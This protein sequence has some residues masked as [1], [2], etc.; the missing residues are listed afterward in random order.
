M[1][2]R[3]TRTALALA[4]ALASGGV[5]ALGLG[6][7][8][9]KS[10]S[11]QPLLAE[12]PIVSS[13]PAE[14]EQLQARLASP[15]TFTRIGL[16]PPQGIVSDLQFQVALDARGNP[17]IRVTSQQPV[18]QPL[19]TFLV[20]VDWGQGRL[21]REY[22]A[23]IDTPKTVS[24]PL[25]PPI[26]APVTAPSN[27]IER[28]LDPAAVIASDSP[29]DPAAVTP[30]A[31]DPIPVVPAPAPG[32]AYPAQPTAIAIAPP[33]PSP[34]APLDAAPAREDGSIAVKR[35]D[36]LSRIASGLELGDGYSLDQTMV[37][38][39]RANPDAFI[40]G[41]VNRLKQGAV[42]RVPPGNEV[43]SIDAGEASALVRSQ[44]Q[45]WRQARRPAPQPA[46]EAVP[47]AVAPRAAGNSAGTATDAAAAAGARLE[48][49]PPGASRAARAGTQSG[50]NA[51][52]GGEMLRQ[53]L[54]ESKESLAARE[55]ELQDLKG[56]V[57]EL[58]QLQKQ[59]QQLIQLKDTELAAAQQ[60]LSESNQKQAAAQGGAML[61][62]AITG[63]VLLLAVL[64][65]WFMRRRP[66]KPVFR[67]PLAAGA[68]PSI[69]DAFAESAA[70]PAA[71]EPAMAEPER[72]ETPA[73]APAAAAATPVPFW[74]AAQSAPAERKVPAWHVAAVGH[75]D[76]APVQEP[77]LAAQPGQERLELARAYMD[78]GD[79]EGA[80]QLLG[81][82]A[83]TGDLAARQQ[84]ARM[85]RE[86]E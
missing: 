28:P 49:V 82:V 57:A 26:E 17:V 55:A 4:L 2:H 27:L 15:E 42:L 46:V 75:G 7:I 19:V 37:A 1:K 66:S 39:L 20:E 21:V 50:I 10:R 53:E 31:V 30:D 64:G 23:L 34:A 22:S 71:V 8:E 69:A 6:Q 62:W 77:L 61:P 65:A 43:A 29:A 12:I 86:L 54:Q 70:A 13:D 76:S 44:I 33:P 9:V 59:Q 5:C 80:R 25:Q 83:V 85:L 3:F 67:A 35:G 32:N 73:A 38:L 58:E 24:A 72:A 60:R 48:I 52:G 45:Q 81:E 68:A 74:S 14:L 47:L 11:D 18:N 56:R 84:A 51:G 78:L 63:T 41:D 16:M 36:S 79:H 40:G